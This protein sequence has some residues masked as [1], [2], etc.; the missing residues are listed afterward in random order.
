MKAEP[1]KLSRFR[2]LGSRSWNTAAILEPDRPQMTRPCKTITLLLVARCGVDLM[3][4]WARPAWCGASRNAI[5]RPRLAPP[6][7][8]PL[9]DQADEAHRIVLSPEDVRTG[10]PIEA[11][12]RQHHAGSTTLSRLATVYQKIAGRDVLVGHLLRRPVKSLTVQACQQL[13]ARL[14]PLA[15]LNPSTARAV[16]NGWHGK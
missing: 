12:E 6:P 16:P 13:R 10:I 7:T 15:S 8:A 4:C 2:I 11:A 9:S 14:L 1:L 3:G 5:R